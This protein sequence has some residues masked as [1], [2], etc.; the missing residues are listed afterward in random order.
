MC[1]NTQ[2]TCECVLQSGAHGGLQ[3]DRV[4][5]GRGDAVHE[6]ADGALV[7]PQGSQ[8]VPMG[9]VLLHSVIN[10]DVE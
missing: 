9:G 5:V 4:V 6:A 3:E 8:R 2:C 10:Y 1:T 7:Q